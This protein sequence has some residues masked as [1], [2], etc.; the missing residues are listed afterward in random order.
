MRIR[1]KRILA[2]VLSVVIMSVV[3][4]PVRATTITDLENLIEQ[5]KGKLEEINDQIGDICQST[6]SK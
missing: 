6:E 5:N 2:L 1:T 4:E 3:V